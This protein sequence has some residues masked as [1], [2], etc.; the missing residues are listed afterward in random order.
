[1]PFILSGEADR[2]LH[3]RPGRGEPLVR[4]PPEQHGLG[5]ERLVQLELVAF[6]TAVELERPTAVLEVLGSSGVLHHAVE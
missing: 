1:M 2:I 6:V 3:R 5:L 4:H